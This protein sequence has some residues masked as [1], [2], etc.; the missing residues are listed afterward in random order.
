MTAT[1]TSHGK[2][3]GEE[4]FGKLFD[5]SAFVDDADALRRSIDERGYLF[6]RGVSNAADVLSAREEIFS[7]LAEVGEIRTDRPVTDGIATGTSRRAETVGDLGE[8]WRS[9]SEGPRLRRVTHDG[10][11]VALFEKLFGE[12]ARPFD[13]VWV[14]TMTPGRA[15]G[16]HYDHVYMNRGTDRLYSAWI[17]LGDVPLQEGPLL[18]VEGSHRFLDLIREYRGLDV[19]RNPAKSGT[20]SVDPTE[21]ADRYGVRLLSE[22]FRAGD[23]LVLSMFCLHGSLDNRSGEG[24]IRLSCDAR[25]QPASEP[26][27]ERWTG[28]SPV[29][30]GGGYASMSAARPLTAD[31]I[32]R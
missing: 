20:I 14:R 31:P 22:D 19:D 8:F 11:V 32:F 25:Y 29:G 23:L 28:P 7:K 12:P 24:R 17:P 6:L 27:D 16:F 30:H 9:V 21:V 2:P 4:R 15:S 5:A 10:P 1:W 18:V 3:I 13:F 26:A